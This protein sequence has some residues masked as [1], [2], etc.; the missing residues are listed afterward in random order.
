MENMN[1]SSPMQN[2]ACEQS[3]KLCS[4]NEFL[5]YL[6]IYQPDVLADV[7]NRICGNLA[8]SPQYVSAQLDWLYQ[9]L[10]DSPARKYADQYCYFY[11]E[12]PSV[13][14]I[15]E[16]EKDAL[17]VQKLNAYLEWFKSTETAAAIKAYRTHYLRFINRLNLPEY[18]TVVS[19]SMFDE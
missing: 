11:F 18:L 17:A 4:L 14:D 10:P 3:H 13:L 5:V 16:D 8:E 1:Y 6:P 19:K 12:A 2:D 7:L 9:H 15:R